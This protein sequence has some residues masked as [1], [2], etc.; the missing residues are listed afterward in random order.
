M[1]KYQT[2]PKKTL[3]EVV[4]PLTDEAGKDGLFDDCPLCQEMRR[5]IELGTVRAGYIQWEDKDAD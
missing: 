4:V 3:Y 5:E 1:N 2:D